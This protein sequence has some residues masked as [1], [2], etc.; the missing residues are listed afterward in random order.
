[1]HAV[2]KSIEEIIVLF[3]N[4][5]DYN[6]KVTRYQVEHLAGLRGSGTRYSVPSCQKLLTQSLCF[7]TE[8]C[9]GIRN[10]IQFG[11]RMDPG[12]QVSS[13]PSPLRASS[14]PVKIN[15]QGKVLHLSRVHLENITSSMASLLKARS[16]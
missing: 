2:G 3:Q 9:N 14:R 8:K 1:M 7:A 10:P 6:E 15:Q 13:S 5:P 11:R 12:K 16:T 4:A